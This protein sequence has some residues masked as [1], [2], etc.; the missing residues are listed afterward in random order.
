MDIFIISLGDRLRALRDEHRALNRI[1]RLRK[2]R[3]IFFA[4]QRK[5]VRRYRASPARGVVTTGDD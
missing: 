4:R 3:Y 2:R 1:R 5:G